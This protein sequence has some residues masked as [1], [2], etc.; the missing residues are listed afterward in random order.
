[1]GTVSASIKSMQE[2]LFRLLKEEN[3]LKW[4]RVNFMQL[5]PLDQQVNF[6]FVCMKERLQCIWQILD[7]WRD[8]TDFHLV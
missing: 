2:N 4:K 8:K 5:R 3:K 1:M 6:C 7:T